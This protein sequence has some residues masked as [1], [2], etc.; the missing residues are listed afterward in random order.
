MKHVGSNTRID[1]QYGQDAEFD[2]GNSGTSKTI[3]FNNGNVQKVSMTGNCTFTFSNGIACTRYMLKLVQGSGGN[4]YT[5][6][7][8]VKW[9]GGVSAPTGSGAS[10]TDLVMFYF[11]GTSYLGSYLL[12]Y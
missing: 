10:K 1:G 4:T 6:P 2:A 8:T 11:D 7:G 12:G 3:D 5:W 9:P